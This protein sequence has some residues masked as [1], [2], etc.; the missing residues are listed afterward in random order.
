MDLE[1]LNVHSRSCTRRRRAEAGAQTGS[2]ECECRVLKK[3]I[4]KFVVKSISLD[5]KLKDHAHK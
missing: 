3:S 5:L 1:L 2:L 4:M